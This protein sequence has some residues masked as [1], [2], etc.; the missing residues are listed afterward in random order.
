MKDSIVRLDRVSRAYGNV[1]ALRD[2]SLDLAQGSCYGLLGRNGAGK[3]TVLRLIMGMIRSDG[4]QVRVF[5][6]DPFAEPERAK[7]AVG[8][9]A[10]DL[11]FPS[12]LRPS[13]IFRFFAGC[14]PPWDWGFAEDLVR[15]LGLPIDR[16]LHKLSKGQQR[17]AG[18]VCALA[19]RPRLLVLDEPGGGLDPVVRREFL[20]QVIDLLG[21][22]E[23]TVLFSSHNL[24]EV[25]RIANRVA[26]LHLGRKLI[27]ED[28]DVLR[29]NACRVLAE[30][31]GVDEAAAKSLE[32][33]VRA[34]RKD[35]AWILTLRCTPDEGRQRVAAK[36]G[37]RIR[38]V[39]PLT[40]EDLF[41]SLV[42]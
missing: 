39:Q 30:A 18:L 7:I 13:D 26:I 16:A 9:L 11:A 31:D 29:E 28:L 12:S 3:S 38:D 5:G 34:V 25:E 22:Q 10:E 27:E 40:L 23:T 33:C 36:L 41:I 42:G 19:H 1:D 20:E 24:Q 35:G 14:H 15:R 4:G 2:F 37:A 21:T 6:H 32:G 17:Q 8:F